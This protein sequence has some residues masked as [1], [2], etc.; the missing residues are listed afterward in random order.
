MWRVESQDDPT[1]YAGWGE[2][3]IEADPATLADLADLVDGPYQVALTVTGPFAD[4]TSMEDELGV[5]LFAVQAVIPGPFTITGTPPAG[6]P[7][8][9]PE[10]A[11]P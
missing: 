8:D 4:V 10:E 6:P 11:T 1:R 9:V 5:Y 2:G 7:A 3:G